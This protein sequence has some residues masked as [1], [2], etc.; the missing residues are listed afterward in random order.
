MVTS[1]TIDFAFTD[2]HGRRHVLHAKYVAGHE[3]HLQASL[4]GRTFD[5]RCSDWQRVERA[6]RWLRAHAHTW[7]TPAR[8]A[9]AVVML[10]AASMV[11]TP[12]GFAQEHPP[13]P[14]GIARFLQTADDYTRMHRRLEQV[15]PPLEIN[16]NPAT[17]RRAIDALAAAIRAERRDAAEGDLFNPDAQDIIRASIGTALRG[18]GLAVID[19]LAAERAEGIDAGTIELTVNRTFPWA[20]ATAMFPCV[21]RTLPPL[22]PELTYRI[23]GRDLV[24]IDIHAGLVVDIL[25]LALVDP[26]GTSANAEGPTLPITF[27]RR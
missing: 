6:L 8:R 10:I 24:L 16:A 26:G 27:Q 21:L 7:P 4:D 15:L 20:I 3:W 9:L 11:F 22:P 5:R 2:V 12:P 14:D 23:V 25:R 19:V 18:H 13:T 17:I 1:T